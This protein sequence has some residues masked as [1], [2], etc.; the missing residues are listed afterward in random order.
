MSNRKKIIISIFSLLLCILVTFAWINELQNPE[1]RVLALRFKDAAIADSDLS[2]KLF[3]NHNGDN[4]TDITKLYDENN[5]EQL[6]LFN[7]FAPGSRKKFRVDIINKAK[8]PASLRII[9]SDIICDNPKLKEK[10]II[11]TNGFAGFDA[12][13]PEPIVK[14][15]TLAVGMGDSLNF[16]LLDHVEVPP[17]NTNK[18]ISV[19]FYVMFSSSGTEIFENTS[20]SIGTINF[21]TT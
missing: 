11:G 14:N 3:V 17:E 9:L 16:V 2:V 13:Y 20:F 6:E 5:P 21:L 7:N 15:D 1:G 12:E 10:I 19:Y 4:F 18:P 8:S